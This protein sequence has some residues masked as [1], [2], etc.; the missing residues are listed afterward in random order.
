MKNNKYVHYRMFR[1][2]PLLAGILFLGVVDVQHVAITQSCVTGFHSESFLSMRAADRYACMWTEAPLQTLP[3]VF[4]MDATAAA[5]LLVN[6]SNKM[7]M[8]RRCLCEDWLNE[9]PLPGT[10]LRVK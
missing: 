5:T 6:S 8:I 2:R 3:H 10:R 9:M 4:E 1:E 7:M